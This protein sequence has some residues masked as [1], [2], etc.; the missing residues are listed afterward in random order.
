M[1]QTLSSLKSLTLLL[2]GTCFFSMS[3]K[4]ALIPQ[5]PD[6]DASGY[7]LMDVA[8]GQFIVAHNADEKLPPAS[9]T[10]IMTDYIA[11]YEIGR[12]NLALDESV[13][14]SVKAWRMG[15]SRMFIREGTKVSV[16]DLLKGIAIQSG[17]DAS[18]AIA[19]HIAGSE[20]SFADLMNQHAHRLGMRNTHFV[21]ATGWPAED[22]YSSA[23]D[24]AILSRALIREFPENYALYREKSFTFNGISQQNRNLLL[25]RDTTVD[26]IKTGHT[27]EAGYCLVAS[28]ERDGMRLISV[29]MGTD[30]ENARA[31]E[32]QQLLNYGFRFYETYHAY[33]TGHSLASAR[34]WKGSQDNIELGPQE[35]VVLTIPRGSHGDLDAEIT[36][37]P[38][39]T[40]PVNAGD[41]L[42]D[43]TIRLEGQVLY[44]QPLVA[45]ADVQQA[46][47]FKRL[48]HSLLLLI[49][50]FLA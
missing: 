36:L 12:G 48:W 4:A 45:L 42:G 22:H 47:V 49:R 50:S 1:K 13:H 27:N 23:R 16:E 34:V 28:A 2:L 33:N 9:L 3:V 15:G 46:G 5:P 14:I 17:N 24:M 29:V 11:A 25:W 21:N 43:I 44:Q 6:V 7:L 39:V 37:A 31:R 30:S 8:S 26:G 10:K 32:S 40:A 41:V 35:D 18:V 19:E 20:E 38:D